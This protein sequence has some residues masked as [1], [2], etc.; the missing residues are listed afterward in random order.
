MKNILIIVL[1][2]F[3]AGLQAQILPNQSPEKTPQ[4]SDAIYTQENGQLNK[5]LFDSAF[6]YFIPRINT[7]ILG[8]NLD[9]LN[10]TNPDSLRGQFVRDVSEFW[11][12]VDSSGYALK[13]GASS[14]G[15]GGFT[16]EQVQD[17]VGAMVSGNTETLITVT[18]ND[19][20]AVLNFVIENDLS[21]YDNTTSG[22]LT[23]EVDGNTT[24]ELQTV[25]TFEL[26]GNTLRLSLL[27]DGE[28]AK[29]VSLSGLGGGGADN[30]TISLSND[31]LSIENGNEVVLPYLEQSEISVIISDTA[32]VLR[33]YTDQAEQDAKDYADA[34]D[35]DTQLSQ[36]QVE[37]FSGALFTGNIESLITSTYNDATGKVD[38]TVEAA[39]SNYTN[40]A[41]FLTT[42]VDGDTLN[43][44]QTLSVSGGDIV[45][46]DG[47]DS[48][49]IIN[50][51][52]S[53]TAGS[54]TI[55]IDLQSARNRIVQIDMTSASTASTVT[56]TASN[57]VTGGV[58][59]IHFQ[60]TNAGGHD[61]DFPTTFLKADGT[62]WDGSTTVNYAADDWLTCYY[63]GTNYHCK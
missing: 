60:N 15:G 28:A 37:D 57:P 35:T 48:I 10:A 16:T 38:L 47:G 9:T 5:I 53:N 34:N 45:L 6:H 42:E 4:G 58:Y 11:H 49:S 26:S 14:G 3:A 63:D 52:E 31:T 29:E 24:N 46:S 62:A 22:F 40:D 25:D 56:L 61:V 33:A 20:G 36:E 59:T 8:Y 12:Y 51:V 39:L 19:V 21:L 41:G 7:N 18:Y 43:E 17:I 32:T 2:F 27:N 44:I 30:Q 54:T 13:F 1:L 23:S 55:T 50:T